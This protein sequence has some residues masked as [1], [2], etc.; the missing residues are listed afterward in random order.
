MYHG[1]DEDLCSHCAKYCIVK[2]REIVRLSTP[3]LYNSKTNYKTKI[4]SFED[5]N[6]QMGTGDT[7]RLSNLPKVMPDT[8]A[9]AEN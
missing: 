5:S 8:C 6:A 4:L 7:D 9:R 2:Y 1:T 3:R